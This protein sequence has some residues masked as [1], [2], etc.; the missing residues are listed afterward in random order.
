[1]QDI[2]PHSGTTVGALSGSLKP[3]RDATVQSIVRA[4]QILDTLRDFHELS[5]TELSRKMGLHKSTT[6]RLLAT[7]EG[8]G[9]VRQDRLTERYSLGMKVLGLAGSLLNQ[10][11]I[12]S[13][14]LPVMRQLMQETHETVHLGVLV[15]EQ[16]MCIESVISPR[17]NAIASMAGKFTHAHVSSMGKAILAA[18]SPEAVD[19]FHQHR[20][21]PRLTKFTITTPG[22]FKKELA[23]IRACGYAVNREEEELGIRC[24]ASAVFDHTNTPVAAISVAAPAPR[25]EGALLD[26]IGAYL[27]RRARDISQNLGAE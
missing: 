7:L 17:T 2:V 25:L 23:T 24:A 21:L 8:E 12:R 20:G 3:G 4:T 27:S 16:V 5:V 22:A 10:L 1:V 9:Y 18:S 6:H 19:A 11:D 14:A 26:K 13:Y 15:N